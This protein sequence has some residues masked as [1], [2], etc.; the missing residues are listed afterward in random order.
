MDNFTCKQEV[1]NCLIILTEQVLVVI[2]SFTNEFAQFQPD[3]VN[4]PLASNEK[5]NDVDVWLW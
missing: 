2:T 4:L 1:K 3:N 5:G